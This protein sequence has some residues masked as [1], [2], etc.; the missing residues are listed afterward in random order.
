MK[1]SEFW[2]VCANTQTRVLP[3]D[4][5]SAKSPEGLQRIMYISRVWAKERDVTWNTKKGKSEVLESEEKEK[6]PLQTG[7]QSTKRS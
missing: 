5:L 4:M 1:D 2:N 7:A 3:V 6:T